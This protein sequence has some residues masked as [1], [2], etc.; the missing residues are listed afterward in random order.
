MDDSR[1][2]FC[3]VT[4]IALVGATVLPA[5][6]GCGNGSKQIIDAA[7]TTDMLA[8]NDVWEIRLP[9][10][11]IDVCHD[12]AGFYALD[13][14]C[15]HARC[16]ISFNQPMYPGIF[17]CPCHDSTFD[18][19]G[20]NPTTPAS[21]PLPHYKVLLMGTHIYVDFNTVVDPSTRINP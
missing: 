13:A 1:R 4:G 6:P 20:Q 16:L 19:N 3:Q 10:H 7:I 21:V 5:L 2:K 8:L 18:Y 15:T 12:S 17:H 9:D 11:N 14:N